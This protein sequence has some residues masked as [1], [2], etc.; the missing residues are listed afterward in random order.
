[1]VDV[2]GVMGEGVDFEWVGGYWFCVLGVVF[3]YF[4]DE[5]D[6]LVVVV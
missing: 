4:G 2:G 3:E 5:F 6:V 1:M